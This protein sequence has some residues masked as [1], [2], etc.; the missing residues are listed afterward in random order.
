MRNFPHSG[1]FLFCWKKPSQREEYQ[2]AL[3]RDLLQYILQTVS[4][5]CVCS[6]VTLPPT[7][8]SWPN[9]CE[10]RMAEIPWSDQI[11][12][13]RRIKVFLWVLLQPMPQDAGLYRKIIKKN[14]QFWD[15]T[16]QELVRSD[17]FDDRSP[18]Q[19]HEKDHGLVL[20][21]QVAFTNNYQQ[22]RNAPTSKQRLL[23]NERK[24]KDSLHL[25]RLKWYN[26]THT[27][28]QQTEWL[29]ATLRRTMWTKSPFLENGIYMFKSCGSTLM[30]E[31]CRNK[32]MT[33]L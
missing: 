28:E 13:C 11:T 32:F 2:V 31:T 25:A 18:P 20:N 6:P 22:S 29:S 23:R 4:T 5:S 17:P 8:A 10:S 12:K 3:Y 24:N 7:R 9:K 21:V 14:Q 33:S 16:F 19:A 27:S 15:G 26:V 1:A 30:V